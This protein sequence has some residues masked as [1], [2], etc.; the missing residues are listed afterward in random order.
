V[1]REG[2]FEPL[3]RAAYA[4]S[5][6]FRSSH[7]YVCP[8]LKD[9]P[10]R[11]ITSQTLSKLRHA[12]LGRKVD[13]IRAAIYSVQPSE[14]NSLCPQRGRLVGRLVATAVGNVVAWRT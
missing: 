10:A 2:G 13:T 8:P 5:S 14:Y 11:H 9:D 6:L 12:N 1:V 7:N 3:V 4:E